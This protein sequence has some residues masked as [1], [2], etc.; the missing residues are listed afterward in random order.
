MSFSKIGKIYNLS[1]ERIK[2][3]HDNGLNRL[4]NIAGIKDFAIY[5]DNPEK[6]L[7]LIE[8]QKA[9]PK[10]PWVD[11]IYEDFADYNEF[12]INEIL[13]C[14]SK[15]DRNIVYKRY[16]GFVL[17]DYEYDRFWRFIYISIKNRLK[18]IENRRVLKNN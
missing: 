1:S 13:S 15:S 10:S 17:S 3:I 11:S 5:M 12:D 18:E 4:R 8:A 14:L 9:C 2:Q 7:E 16:N 6:S